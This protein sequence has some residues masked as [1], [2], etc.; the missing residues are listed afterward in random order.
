MKP[1]FGT[2]VLKITPAHSSIDF[3]IA[4]R[5]DLP[6]I[7]IFDDNGNIKC[8]YDLFNGV[9]RYAA[10]DLVKSELERMGL[11]C[12]QKDHPHWL[13]VC[14][15]SGDIIE[16]RIVPQWFLKCDDARY[17]TEYVVNTDNLTE[18]SKQKWND[19]KQN[20]DVKN[21]NIFIIPSS[22]R[23][24]WKDWFS[25]YQD[26]CISRQIY[27]GHRIPAYQIYRNSLPTDNWVAA[28][29]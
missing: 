28:K 11:Y 29:K 19:L 25:R 8:D 2:G 12:H 27:W 13:P 10:K 17:I 7:N 16:S 26:W 24:T 6:S 5:H 14:A 4:K 21:R 20:L 1:D 22:Y 9:H 3:E 15:R 18:N 23:N